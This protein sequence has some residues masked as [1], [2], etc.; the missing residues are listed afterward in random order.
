M[1]TV[2]SQYVTIGYRDDAYRVEIYTQGESVADE[3]I[4]VEDAGD[5]S[6][7]NAR[8]RAEQIAEERRLPFQEPL[9]WPNQ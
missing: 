8:V 5:A 2:I 3:V 6:E 7:A 1:M 9:V 4:D